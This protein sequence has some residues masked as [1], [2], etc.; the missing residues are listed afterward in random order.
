MPAPEIAEL[1]ALTSLVMVDNESDILSTGLSRVDRVSLSVARPPRG[2]QVAS[3]IRREICVA[4]DAGRAQTAK[5][6]EPIVN[7]FPK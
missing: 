2:A 3:G 6:H 5:H 1:D 4:P 7:P